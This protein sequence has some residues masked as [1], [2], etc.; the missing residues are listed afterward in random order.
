[1]DVGLGT[2]LA[3]DGGTQS[4]TGAVAP[5]IYQ[6][7][8]FVFDTMDEL[9]AAMA[10]N[11]AGPPYHYSRVGN[12][13]VEL[14][15]KKIAALEGTEACRLFGSGMAAISS[16]ILSCV[17]AGSNVILVDTCYNPTRVLLRDY[18]A[19]FG[20]SLTMVAGTCTDEVLDAIR[21]ETRLV[22][23]ES[24]SSLLFRLQDVAAIATAC[25]ERGISTA[26]D[27]TY[28]TPLHFQPA[29]LGIDLVC[30]SATKFLSGHSDVVAGAICASRERIERIT[31][32]EVSLLGAVLHP[33]SAWLLTRG[34][35]TLQL[36]LRQHEA[37]GNAVA[38][39]LEDRPEVAR[40]HHVSLPSHPQHKLFRR[41]MKGSSGLFSFEP[42]V[43]DADRVKAFAD[44]LRLFGRGV[45]WGGYE[46]LV[47]ALPVHPIDYP[48]PR[49]IVR[50]FCGLEEPED[51]LRDLEQALA[52]IAP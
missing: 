7:S 12:P 40:V 47:I 15:E 34:M 6:T 24:P 8:T 48:E 32:N 37:A 28:S 43:Q 21:P 51:L 20:V 50:L 52:E 18:L 25:R 38:A 10:K 14:A 3:H 44:R 49:W 35:R 5:P 19:K 22:F 42:K 29:K 39:W 41:M 2:L 45:S 17:D 31:R 1:M 36:R 13:S 27:N 33:F 46:S 9:L 16:A 4:H 23:L 11:P 26:I 30:H